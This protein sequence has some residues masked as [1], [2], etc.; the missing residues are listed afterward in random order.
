MTEDGRQR[1]EDRGQNTEGAEHT[2]SPKGRPSIFRRLIKWSLLTVVGFLLLILLLWG[3]IQTPWAKKQIAGLITD[4]TAKTGD[5]KIQIEG[6]DGLLPFS[7]TLKA[8]TLS[9]EKGPWLK[10]EKFD[11]ALQPKD[12]FSGL[13]N[14]KWLKM[15]HVAL[16][17]LPES[18]DAPAP[19]KEPAQTSGPLSLP[20]VMVQEIRLDRLDIGEALAGRPMSFRLTSRVETAKELIKAEVALSDLSSTDNGLGLKAK[21]HLNTQD[22]EAAVSYHEAAGGL[23]AGLAALKD[24]KGIDLTANATGS[25]TNIRGNLNLNVGGYGKTALRFDVAHKESTALM[26]KGNIIPD[27]QILPPQAAKIMTSQ[28]VDLALNASLSPQRSVRVEEF[29]MKNGD[30]IIGMAGTADLKKENMDLKIRMQ[31][32]DPAPL[33]DG[34]GI[35]VE[36]LE[37]V[38]ISAK[39]PFTAPDV[40]IATKFSGLK[41]EGAGLKEAA[42]NIRAVV[43]KGFG[44]LKN[45]ALTLGA[46]ELS[47]QQTPKLKGPLTI[48]MNAKSPDFSKWQVKNLNVT[49]P[50]VDVRMTD[51]SITLPHSDFS[52]DMKIQVDH[53]AAL[54]P[55]DTPDMDGG[56]SVD[57]RIKGTAPENLTAQ[58]NLAL[59][60]LKGLPPQA[61]AMAG[62][63]VTLLADAQLNGDKLTLESVKLSGAQARLDSNGWLN[64]S[65]KSFDLAYRLNLDNASK[66]PPKA[67]DIPVGDLKSQGKLTG[68]FDDFSAKLALDSHSLK[69]NNLEITGMNARLNASGLPS[70]P[71]GNIRLEAS[72]MDQPVNVSSDFSWNGKSLS[73]QT[74]KVVLPGIDIAASL[75]FAPGTERVSGTAKGRI[76]SLEMVQALTGVPAKGKG[77]FQIQAGRASN[78]NADP[79]LELNANFTGLRYQEYSVSDLK[80]KARVDDMHKL[81]G[82]ASLVASD[83][84]VGNAQIETVNLDLKGALSDAQITFK[85]KGS[86]Q[87]DPDTG[88]APFS[89]STSLRAGKKDRWQ[90]RLDT[91]KASYE[92]LKVDLQKPASLTVGEK[93]QLALDDL[94]IKL[95]KGLLKASADM[96]QGNAAARIRISDLPLSLLEPILGQEIEGK[97]AMDLNL[98]GPLSDP[99]VQLAVNV[100]NYK[101]LTT[102]GAKPILLNAKLNTKL[103]GNRAL[104]DLELSGIGKT[105]FKAKGS[106][107]A[108]LSLKPFSF[109]LDKTGQLQGKLWGNF[110]LAVLKTLPAMSDQTLRGKIDIDLGVGGSVDKWALNGGVTIRNG[111]FEN[112]E[113]GM[114]LERIEGRV[115]AE[116][117]VLKL[118]NLSATDGGTGT[119][120]LTGQTEVNPPF[121]T[122]ISLTLKEA[123]LL[124][125][126]TLSVTAG[127][128]LNIK[129]NKSR[130]DL[131]GEID[132]ERTEIQIPKR[133]PPDVPVIPVTTINDPSAVEAEKSKAKEK[134][135]N[136]QMDLGVNIPHKFF[137]RGRGLDVEFKGKLKAKGP[138]TNPV[139]TGTLNVVRG[140]F[141]CFSRTFKVTSGQIAFDGSAPPVPFLNINTEVNAGEILAKLDISGPA[142]AFKLKVSSQPTLPQDEIL[143]QILFGQSVAK[144]NTFQALQLAYSVNEL[145]GGYGPDVLGKTRSFLGLDRIGFSGG[146]DSGSS[147]KDD[148]NSTGPSVTLGKYVTD[149][150]YVG[151]EQDLTDAKQD[152]IVE[153]DITPNFTVE[154][155]A[156]SRSGA[157]VGFNWNYDY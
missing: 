22:L 63:R 138:A 12:L 20:P 141:L 90:V 129:G 21:Y 132:L 5:Y 91:L 99:G 7:I 133:F 123:T 61:A 134:P 46:Q 143:A 115:D 4:F 49:L 85:T 72:A 2:A 147:S 104:A 107:P 108:R 135:I 33:L 94:E 120:S 44:G 127:G 41:A 30:I 9:D 25:V 8:A 69:L 153:I 6:L 43:E 39:G 103:E 137:V 97:L 65:K 146:E 98:S 73:V 64:L 144:L 29:K 27:A 76:A 116:G 83:I 109:D 13:I 68:N 96:N 148:E 53:I 38:S 119:I 122:D 125:K 23:V 14:V 82:R 156:G 16:S 95:D 117:K 78:K 47:V 142:D 89:L 145:A 58:L 152:V 40:T 92:G 15:E 70:K 57:A 24:V 86:A 18:R 150:V 51:V 105:P 34:T 80:L 81:Q 93:G 11:F 26:L 100:Q 45:A 77:T 154:S 60:N 151:V 128:D 1:T 114:L 35:S 48:D 55:P 28:D 136:I 84:P 71:S 37:P 56:V 67:G 62:S 112:V 31:G 121:S 111:H 75:D 157:G 52:G 54:V 50:G 155:K 74:A 110:D 113:Q 139:I 140:T 87:T 118:T 59:T 126:E 10:I 88:K 102:D 130:M 36:G 17:R 149:R 124:R 79:T 3:V 32:I 66:A 106:L 19:K 101:I 42:L 131:A